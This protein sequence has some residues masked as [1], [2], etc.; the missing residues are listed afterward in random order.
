[1]VGR[2]RR[3][4]VSDMGM[5]LVEGKD[6]FNSEAAERSRVNVLKSAYYYEGTKS[7]TTCTDL[8]ASSYY[9]R[10]SLTAMSAAH[11]PLLEEQIEPDDIGGDIGSAPSSNKARPAPVVLT[12]TNR[13]TEN[14]ATTQSDAEAGVGAELHFTLV[15]YFLQG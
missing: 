5:S 9:W 2:L 7:A 13:A 1:M 11:T 15:P 12:A 14:L 10:L 8:F 6:L 4:L 3:G